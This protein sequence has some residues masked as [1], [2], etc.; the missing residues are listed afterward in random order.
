MATSVRSA[1]RA[2][3]QIASLRVT[4]GSVS[5][6]SIKGTVKNG[7]SNITGFST[8]GRGSRIM[9]SNI[10]VAVITDLRYHLS[11]L[12]EFELR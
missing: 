4:A 8:V 11:L 5:P 6:D 9:E 2:I 7:V 1:I 12:V 10:C 3:M